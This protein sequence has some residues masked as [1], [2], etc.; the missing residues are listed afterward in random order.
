MM[1]HN[2]YSTAPQDAHE[3]E[4]LAHVHP[5]AW[6][7]PQP[8]ERYS[9]VVIGRQDRWRRTLRRHWARRSR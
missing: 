4:R 2:I 6:R 8:A 9:L 7:N 3:R 5:A 1:Q